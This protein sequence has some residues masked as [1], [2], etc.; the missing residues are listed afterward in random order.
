MERELPAQGAECH[1]STN[2]VRKCGCELV[3][4][5]DVLLNEDLFREVVC[6]CLR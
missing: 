6:N 1:L 5:H 4:T 3:D 2:S